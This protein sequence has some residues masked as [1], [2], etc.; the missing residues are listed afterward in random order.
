ML[1]NMSF[2]LIKKHYPVATLDEHIK[3]T[4]IAEKQS[5]RELQISFY[6]F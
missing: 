3:Q 2:F 6:A 4:K 5:A 1:N